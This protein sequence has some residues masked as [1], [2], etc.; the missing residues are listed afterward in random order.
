MVDFRLP[1]CINTDNRLMSN[2]T[3]TKELIIATNTFNLSP[4]QTRRI[5][6]QGF[7][8]AFFPGAPKEKKAY[9]ALVE[10]Y[11]DRIEQEFK[12]E[13]NK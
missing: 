9:L 2:T 6:L 10:E 8:S 13:T 12:N 3:M 5:V 1:V 4:S 11:Y 7:K